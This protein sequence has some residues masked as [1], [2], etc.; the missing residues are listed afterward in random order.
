M[1][2]F[3]LVTGNFCRITSIHFTNAH[4][5]SSWDSQF[6]LLIYIQVYSNRRI[7]EIETNT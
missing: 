5:Q 1:K 3:D 2:R 6:K 4:K 7:R